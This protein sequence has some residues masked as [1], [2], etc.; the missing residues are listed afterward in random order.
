VFSFDFWDDYAA[1]RQ[2]RER[3]L[4]DTSERLT[5][6]ELIDNAEITP[7]E[8]RELLKTLTQESQDVKGGYR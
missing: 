7:E 5:L 8:R 1:A 6:K 2:I 4:S 3:D